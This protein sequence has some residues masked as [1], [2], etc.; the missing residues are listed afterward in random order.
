MTNV[1]WA[2]QAD[3]I[4]YDKNKKQILYDNAVED[5]RCTNNIFSK[6]F[7]PGPKVK[8]QSGLLVPRINNLIS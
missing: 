2:I 4:T 6:F 5:L 7:H 3:K 1:L 8:R